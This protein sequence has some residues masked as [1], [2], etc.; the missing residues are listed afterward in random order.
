MDVKV[1]GS[2]F[3]FKF[4][5]YTAKLYNIN[6]KDKSIIRVEKQGFYDENKQGRGE[7]LEDNYCKVY[8]ENRINNEIREKYPEFCNH[9][10]V[11]KINADISYSTTPIEEGVS[12][13]KDE[14]G[15]FIPLK[16]KL[17]GILDV[18]LKTRDFSES[19]LEELFLLIK[20]FDNTQMQISLFI[21]GKNEEIET[22]NSTARTNLID[23]ECDKFK[24]IQSVEDLRKVITDF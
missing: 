5:Y 23:I 14:N 9:K 19:F 17:N 1:A 22:G 4:D 11:E 10:D 8:W 7:R 18:D 13:I 21:T 16:P 24:D 2:S 12:T 6:D 15:V 20:E 3:N